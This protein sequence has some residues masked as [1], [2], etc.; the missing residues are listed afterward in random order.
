MK[1]VRRQMEEDEDALMAGLRGSSLNEEDFASA[2]VNMRLLD[3][4]GS[5]ANVGSE[6]AL[7]LVYSP[8]GIAAYWG[9]RKGAIA[10]RIVQLTSVAGSFVA[11]L[12][13]DAVRGTLK[14]NE[15]K[16]AIE[17]RDIVTSLGPAYIKIGQALAI[18]PDLLSPAAMV[19]L[20]RL[21]DKVPSFDS[22]IAYECIEEELGK[23][24]SEV[25]ASSPRAHRR[26]EPGTGIQGQAV[27][28]GDRG[29][30]V[31]RLRP[32]DSHHRPVHHPDDRAVAAQL[33]R[34]RRA[35][36]CCRVARRVGRAVLRGARLRA[37]GRQR[38]ALRLPRVVVPKTYA[39]HLAEGAHDLVVE[40]EKL[41]QSTADDVG[42]LVNVVLCYLKQL[43][44]PASS[45]LT[46]PGNLIRT[47]DGKLA[48]L[49][50]G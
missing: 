32:G 21:C 19:E 14:E 2:D 9:A 49:D 3:F 11:G 44:T 35:R 27:F 46:H 15:V 37:R 48:V 20:Q 29:G 28:P 42:D 23:P 36:G 47:P 22:K 13:L 18:R 10:K 5:S 50:A 31:Q 30:Q 33:P 26:G 16:R 6:D 7:P 39:V 45:M 40:G 8:T 25:Y 34:A 43:W 24:V 17:L 41:S 4:D 1:D 38:H 12:A